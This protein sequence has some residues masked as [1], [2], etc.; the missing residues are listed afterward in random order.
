M[1]EAYKKHPPLKIQIQIE[2]I[3]A[4]E[5]NVILGTRQGHLLMYSIK[6]NPQEQKIDLQLLQYNKTFS[7]KPI[8]QLEVI[9][10]LKIL[11]R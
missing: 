5:N 10:E 8:V 7:K 9:P 11:F 6:S 1:H 3:A 4:F 2:S